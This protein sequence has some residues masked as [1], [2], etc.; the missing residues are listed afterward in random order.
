ML[1]NFNGW[2]GEQRNMGM[3]SKNDVKERWKN[4]FGRAFAREDR[5]ADDNVTAAEYVIDDGNESKITMYE[6]MKTLK[7]MKVGKAAGHDLEKA[8]EKER[9]EMIY[10]EHYSFMYFVS[11]GLIQALQLLY[12]GSSACVRINVAYTDRA[13]NQTHNSDLTS[14]LRPSTM[15]GSLPK[16]H[17]KFSSNSDYSGRLQTAEGQI[18]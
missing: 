10:G 8:Y 5:V 6:I 17:G 15:Q 9:R 1:G 2:V 7:R 11:S 14:E 18:T 4:Y 13:K 16:A 12:R 3:S